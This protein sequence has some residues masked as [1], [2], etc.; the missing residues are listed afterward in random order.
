[1]YP[2]VSRGRALPVFPR[3]EASGYPSAKAGDRMLSYPVAAGGPTV[4]SDDD[5]TALSPLGAED[6][7]LCPA[8]DEP[9][10]IGDDLPPLVA[11][12]SA[13]VNELAECWR[14]HG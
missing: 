1:M 2:K 5:L 4:G 6:I 14:S 7:N 9:V 11:I 13:E 12:L 3:A 10:A 8:M